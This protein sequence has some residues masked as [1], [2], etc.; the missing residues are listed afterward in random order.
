M[1]DVII[2]GAGVIGSFIAH[3]LC[4][5][6]LSIH[7]IEKED[8]V[9]NVTSMANS[10]IIH[11]GYDPLPH[12]KK[13]YYNV[14]GNEMYTKVTEDLDIPF[15][16]I[17]SL[18]LAFSNEEM[19]ELKKLQQRAI[20][21][22]VI[23]RLLTKEEVLELEPSIS[24]SVYGALEAPS[25]GII[26]PFLLCTRLMEHAIDHNVHLHLSEE[27][28]NILPISGGY[29]VVTNRQKYEAK[30]VI[31]A[32]GMGA[33]Q[34][35]SFLEKPRYH[36]TPRKGEYFVLDHFDPFFLRHTLFTLPSKKGKGVLISPTTSMNFLV[37]P[38]SE[39]SSE[40]DNR[41]DNE[42]LMMIREQALKMIPNIPFQETIRVFAGVRPT[43][44]THD[45]IIRHSRKNPHFIELAGIESPGLASAP[46]ISKKVE[47]MVKRILH[48]KRKEHYSSK[49]KKYPKF[50]HFLSNKAQKMIKENP[51]YGKI[52]CRCEKVSEQEIRDLFQRSF[53]PTTIKGVKKRLR[54][55]FG[56]CQGGMCQPL[57]L[58]ILKEELAKKATEVRYDGENSEIVKEDLK[59]KTHDEN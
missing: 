12:S 5:Y 42:T 35:T 34:I 24:S 57:I 50:P 55:G 7:V 33:Y 54:T 13:A 25:A 58:R 17:G 2:I 38:S 16:R 56:K 1:E 44:S 43:I 47:G 29:Q 51:L 32:A 4:K 26:N 15:S 45:F 28:V 30:V 53:Y 27:V 48:P 41:T 21:N 36:L 8:D 11:S 10:A 37:G 19:E 39:P 31:N 22:G 14:K 6:Q 52:I 46:M 18:T 9:G 20:E 3:D 23:V 40:D 49:I 59:E